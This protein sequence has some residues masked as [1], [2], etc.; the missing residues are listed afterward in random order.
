M[1]NGTDRPRGRGGHGATVSIFDNVLEVRSTSCGGPGSDCT[2]ECEGW[3]LA[4]IMQNRRKT[5]HWLRL[6]KYAYFVQQSFPYITPGFSLAHRSPCLACLQI[7]E[8]GSRP[9][10]IHE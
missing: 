3:M 9:V 4:H 1:G 2:A 5:L 6:P 10:G 7:D 8:S